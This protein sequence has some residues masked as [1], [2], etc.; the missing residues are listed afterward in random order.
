M[1]NRHVRANHVTQRMILLQDLE[2]G[3]IGDF[4][5]F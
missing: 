1:L 2:G 4:R 3:G 5:V